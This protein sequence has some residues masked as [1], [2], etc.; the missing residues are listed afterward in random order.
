MLAILKA[1]ISPRRLLRIDGQRHEMKLA[2]K[3]T[4]KF[5]LKEAVSAVAPNFVHTLDAAA[6]M[7]AIC[8]AK[9]RG[10]TDMMAIHDCIAA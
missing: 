2:E 7:L 3:D 1:V 6:M 4:S 9:D 8:E 5:K 10:V